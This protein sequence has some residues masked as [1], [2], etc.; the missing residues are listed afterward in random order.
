M[1]PE[2]VMMI[3]KWFSL[4]IANVHVVLTAIGA[5]HVR[6]V[7]HVVAPAENEL[8]QDLVIVKIAV[9]HCDFTHCCEYAASVAPHVQTH[10][11]QIETNLRC[12][13]LCH[14]VWLVL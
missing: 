6:A 10:L 9:K 14:A 8:W 5:I 4:T 13:E 12:G 1:P 3:K 11:T 7:R 2:P